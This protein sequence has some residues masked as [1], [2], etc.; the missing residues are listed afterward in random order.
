LKCNVISKTAG[1]FCSL[2]AAG[3]LPCCRI[4]AAAALQVYLLPC[5]CCCN[6][7]SAAAAKLKQK[8]LDPQY[9]TEV[10]FHAKQINCS[11]N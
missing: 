8:N 6:S 9:Y 2:A 5:C 4:A 11:I 3:D 10:S 7:N 1:K